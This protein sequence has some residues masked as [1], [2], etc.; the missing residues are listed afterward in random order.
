[1]QMRRAVRCDRL[2]IASTFDPIPTQERHCMC[3]EKLN[4]LITQNV[5]S[6]VTDTALWHR[7][8]SNPELQKAL[9]DLREI[10]AALSAEVARIN[11]GMT[12]HSVK[13][14]DALWNVSDQVLTPDETDKCSA[15]E[16]F[17][18]GSSFY[19]HD[20]GMAFAA[21]KE[22][23]DDLRATQ[24][25]KT[26]L[27]RLSL[28]QNLPENEAKTYA[29]QI[30]GRQ[31]HAFKARELVTQP[32]PGLNQY[33]IETTALRDK[34]ASFIADVSESH[35]W[36]IPEVDTKLGKRG[37]VPAPI[38]GDI[39]LGFVACALR[40]IDYAHINFERAG[41]LA[42]LLRSE[43]GA[44]SALHWAAQEHVTGPRRQG[45]SLVYGCTK[46]IE[47]VEAWW[48]FYEM[49]DGLDR[50][51]HMVEEYL[52]KRADS[53]GR[54][55]L[56]GVKGIRSPQSFSNFILTAGFEPVDIRFKPNSIERLVAILGGRTLY[57]EDVFAPVREL[58]QNARDA[59]Y[60]QR[61]SDQVAGRSPEL[62]RITIALD[63]SDGD[64]AYLVFSD[65]G[66]GMSDDV[67]TNHLLGIASDYWHSPSFYS[68]YPGVRQIGFKPAGKFG[69]GFLSVF[70]AGE[71]VEVESQR[72]GG[73]HLRMRIS[74]VGKRGALITTPSRVSF[75]TT[76]RIELRNQDKIKYQN[77][78]AIV[79]ARAPMLDI[80]IVVSRKT[81]IVT[82]QP[83]WW[84]TVPQEEFHEFVAHWESVALGLNLKHRPRHPY[85]RLN[86]PLAEM[87]EGEK[88]L[89]R[90]PEIITETSRV[91]AIPEQSMVLVCTR[92]I[93][94]QSIFVQGI[95][96]IVEAPDL[97]LVAARS[98]ALHFDVDELRATLVGQLK[99]YIIES[100]NALLDDYI[101]SR[102]EFLAKVGSLYGED[103]LQAT[104]LA[105]IT[106]VDRVGNSTL[107]SPA[108]LRNKLSKEPE[109]LISYGSGPWTS[110]TTAKNHF[111]R[112]TRNALVF[113]IPDKGQPSPGSYNDPEDITVGELSEHFSEEVPVLLRTVVK[114]ISD[115]WG[116]KQQALESTRWSRNKNYTLNVHFDRDKLK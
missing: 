12:D 53:T 51:I 76:V 46:P 9:V 75:G 106:V 59:I 33:L 27:E 23:A 82:I 1:M 45:E 7:M 38:V 90:Q 86:I 67:I 8:D 63:E 54:F 31:L 73:P 87:R 49:A 70:M 15:G 112:A 2:L 56:Q 29:L 19:V 36:A 93:A 94:V 92:G 37:K 24:A 41:L 69:I 35:H 68:N 78:D 84:K 103:V 47:N 91:M 11:P 32:L 5:P 77:L 17:I 40:I 22:G 66:V 88:W 13:H 65:N 4:A 107:M 80:P 60:L 50:E 101:P 104:T 30:A 111:P 55:S 28:V 100:L 109:I 115:A 62:G 64:K 102:F 14:F 18:L 99:P 81:G 21:T 97:D 16:A 108:D 48:L 79:R 74:G 89:T 3:S 98:E 116:V 113:A 43:V 26:A 83:Q 58:L 10:A 61:A 110:R 34:W 85:Y 57:G 114:L 39:D 44:E 6:H 71:N 96:G 52:S 20:L 72:R 42:R 25:Y 105:W 95:T